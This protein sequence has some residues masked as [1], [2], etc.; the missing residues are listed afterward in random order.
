MSVAALKWA[1][2]LEL[3]DATC[4][5]VLLALA[6]HFSDQQQCAWP[7]LARL[8][9]FTSATERTIRRAIDR[10]EDL[11]HVIK[12][13]RPG[14]SSVFYLTF[15]DPGQSDRGTPVRMSA[16]PGQDVRGTPVNLTGHPGQDVRYNSYRTPIE[17]LSNGERASPAPDGARALTSREE[18][19]ARLD[20]YD[21]ADIR[22]TW[23]R[24]WGARPDAM[25]QGHL[26][27]DE[28]LETWLAKRKTAA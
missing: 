1:F 11:G 9:R 3:P 23:N 8:V 20:G 14:H 4:K 17:L 16:P 18:W 10:L 22:K 13:D 28:M 12:E 26:I 27:P 19:Q 5:V 7:S 2:D 15:A 24:F 21:P 6:D 25:G